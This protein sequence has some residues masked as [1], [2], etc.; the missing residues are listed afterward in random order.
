MFS[1]SPSV[2]KNESVP[3][4]TL[5]V[6]FELPVEVVQKIAAGE[7]IDR[8]DAVVKEL[9]ENSLDAGAKK[10][11]IFLENG[12]MKR[13]EVRDDGMGMSTADLQKSFL[14]HTTSKLKTL[15]DL[16]RVGTFGFRGEALS[17]M[18]AVAQ[19][20][21]ESRPSWQKLGTHLKVSGKKIL[22]ENSIGM[23]AGTRIIVESLFSQLPA[24]KKF[25]EKVSRELQ[26]VL[27]RVTQASLAHPQVQFS[28]FHEGKELLSLFPHESLTQRVEAVFGES[29]SHGILPYSA[30][31]EGIQITGFLGKP[32]LSLRSP[33]RQFVF[34]NG[35]AIRNRHIAKA[36]RDAYGP[37]LEPKAYPSFLL[38]MTVPFDHYDA[39]VHPRKEEVLIFHDDIF[40]PQIFENIK[41]FLQKKDL[42]YVVRSG[43]IPEPLLLRDRATHTQFKNQ[44]SKGWHAVQKE[45]KTPEI[46]Q[47]QKTYLLYDD[48]GELMIV[49]QHAAHERVLY[50]EFLDTYTKNITQQGETVTEEKVI[51]MTSENLFLFEKN[52]P[53]FEKIG[54]SFLFKKNGKILTQKIPKIFQ[55][56]D[57]QRILLD[58]LD[59]IQDY[60]AVI[61]PDLL[62]ERALSFLACRSAIK[63]GDTLNPEERL[64][65]VEKLKQLDDAYTCPHGRP[66]KVRI[67][68]Q[69][70][71]KM[72]LRKK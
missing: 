1:L 60:G 37:L 26:Y 54:F 41:Q 56:M 52:I 3:Q 27:R 70:L 50:Q 8:P 15:E 12:G 22:E 13:I 16:S 64:K 36:I 47:F 45:E 17:S 53:F 19:V 18:V 43:N 6:I 11:E 66:L 44:F 67:S 2:V 23:P 57:L 65:I 32:Q 21:L 58:F 40:I 5:S 62:S 49:D 68:L 33:S 63:A 31:L 72:F 42:T 38:Y 46:W 29:F 14:P 71:E 61:K 9:I 51:E 25:I 28:V 10:I 30:Q 24:R 7:V 39:N 59:D 48:Q 55:G 4:K 34:I 69:E 20:T 35:R